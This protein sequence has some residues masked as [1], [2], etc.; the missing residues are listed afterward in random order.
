VSG[1]N[2][3]GG[4]HRD[5]CA[6][7]PA[8]G[9]LVTLHE[10]VPMRE[11]C[12]ASP[13]IGTSAASIASRA[14]TIARGVAIIA[15]RAAMIARGTASGAESSW[16]QLARDSHSGRLHGRREFRINTD[17]RIDSV[18]D[19]AFV[20]RGRNALNDAGTVIGAD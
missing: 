12:L 11:L 9:R 1:G 17:R 18:C 14:A 10:R 4:S 8:E 20:H 19:D 15:R 2:A 13:Q 3:E 5:C 6:F 16:A 7:R